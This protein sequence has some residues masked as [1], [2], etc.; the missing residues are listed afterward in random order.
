AGGLVCAAGALRGAAR[1]GGGGCVLGGGPRHWQAAALDRYLVAVLA[2]GLLLVPASLAD[3]AVE[4]GVI[5]LVAGLAFGPATISMFEVLDVIVPG[6]GAE[7]LTW[8]T[9]AEAAG[10]AAG[11]ALAGVLVLR[12]G[13]GAPFAVAA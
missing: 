9:T 2:L 13:I 8:V 4:L 6:G 12:S 1:G 7:S 3:N 5:L 10:S 11:A